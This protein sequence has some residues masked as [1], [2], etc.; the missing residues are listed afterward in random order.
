[1]RGAPVTEW[2]GIGNS[3][4]E[5]DDIDVREQRQRDERDGPA[6]R[7]T[8]RPIQG[9]ATGHPDDDVNEAGH[10]EHRQGRAFPAQVQ[11]IAAGGTRGP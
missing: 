3:Q 2:S 11:R 6:Q 10:G 7:G 1:M 8:W 5:R 9:A 4:P